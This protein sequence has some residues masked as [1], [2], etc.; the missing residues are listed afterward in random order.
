MHHKPQSA[1][2][3]WL[4]NRTGMSPVYFDFL[5]KI[6]KNNLQFC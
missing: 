6:F 2:P 5:I 4:I 3:S 1:G